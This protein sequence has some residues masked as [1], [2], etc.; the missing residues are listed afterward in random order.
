MSFRLQYFCNTIRKNVNP[1]GEPVCEQK[2]TYTRCVLRIGLSWYGEFFAE[3][4]STRKLAGRQNP[5][6]IL[7]CRFRIRALHLLIMSLDD[8]RTATLA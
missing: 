8:S 3:G 7:Y 4:W 5:Y 2:G 6:P 1:A